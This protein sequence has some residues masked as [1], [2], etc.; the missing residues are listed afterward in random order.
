MHY[1]I[2]F[3]GKPFMLTGTMAILVAAYVFRYDSAGI[4]AVIASLHQIDRSMEEAS[5]SLGASSITTFRKVT[6]PLVVPAVL[7]GMKYLFIH[8]MTAI[9]ATIF[10][11][12]VRWSLLTTRI[13]ECMTELQFGNACA[14][15]IV[16]IAMVFRF[17][18][19]SRPSGQSHG[20][21]L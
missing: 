17:Q 12:S 18:R 7:A 9:S 21:Y 20:T 10:L 1:V 16:L 15:S 14:F 6:F 2:A 3:N 8:S 13:L 11:V 19:Y 4:R 5:M